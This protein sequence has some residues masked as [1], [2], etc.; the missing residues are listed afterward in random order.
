M[1]LSIDGGGIRPSRGG[2]PLVVTRPIFGDA[3]SHRSPALAAVR[4]DEEL[5]LHPAEA[6]RRGLAGETRVRLHTAHGECVLPLRADEAHPEGAA[7]VALGS[8]GGAAGR[9]LPADGASVH[10]EIARAV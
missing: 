1:A 9:L 4:T 2:L 10:V 7:F 8:P 3:T 6:A 5:V